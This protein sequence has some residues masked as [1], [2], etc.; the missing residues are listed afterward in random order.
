[1]IGQLG[2]QGHPDYRLTIHLNVVPSQLIST[3]NEPQL[4]ELLDEERF[5]TYH[6]V[7]GCLRLPA[8]LLVNSA[9]WGENCI[10]VI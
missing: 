6:F 9:M 2:P 4:G 1:M 7:V 8:M 10:I 3:M 5:L